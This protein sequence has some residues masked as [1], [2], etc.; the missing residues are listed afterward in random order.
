MDHIGIGMVGYGMIGRVH[1]LGY[2]AL[3]ILYPGQLPDLMLA[4]VCTRHEETAKAAV[5]EAGFQAWYTHLDDLLKDGAVNVIDCCV[6]NDAHHSVIKKA[7][8]AGKHVYCD[9]PLALNAAQA[10]DLV[11]TAEETGGQVGMTFNYRFLPAIMRASEILRAGELGEIFTFRID[12]LHTGYQNPSRPMGWRLRKEQAGG[13]AMVDLG[14]HVI[15]LVRYLLGE[16]DALHCSTRTFIQQRPVSQGARDME[17]VQVDD[18]AWVRARLHNGAE[19]SLH[20]SRFATGAQDDLSLEIYGSLG[21]LRF[22][23]MDPNW[24]YWYD[25]RRPEGATGGERGWTRIE[26]VQRY[27]GA[28]GLPA[29]APVGWGRTHAENQFAFLRA[30]HLGQPCSPNVMDGY[31]NHLVIEAAYASAETSDWVKVP[32]R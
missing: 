32:R 29:R 20:V 6:P 1:C 12:Y 26:T 10:N 23:L 3:P 16:V 18:A 2:H 30:L 25:A 7:L 21:G 22:N 13:G 4:A 9:K 15:D 31:I 27:P 19:G 24:L 11:Q 5:G 28:S 8:L 14:T 17:S